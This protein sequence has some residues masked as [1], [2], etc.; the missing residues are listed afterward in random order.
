MAK[1]RNTWGSRSTFILAAVGSAVGLGN[2]W[3]FPGLAAKYGGGTFLMVYLLMMLVMG[4]PLLGMEIAIGRKVKRGAAGSMAGLNKKFEPIGWA[5]TNN[6]FFICTYYAVVFAWVIVMAVIAI[7]KFP[8]MTGNPDAAAGIFDKTIMISKSMT[9]FR[10]PIMVII[11]LI[12]AW[13]AIYYCIRNGVK[14]VSKV[15]KYTV[16]LPVIF[17]VIMA[18]KGI[19]MPHA[20]GGLK[21]FFIPQLGAI[22]NPSLWVDATGQVFYSLSIMMAIMLAYGSFLKDDTNIAMDTIII[23]FSDMAVSV[24]SGIVLFT[25]MYGTGMQDKMTDS[26]IATAF[27]VYPMS[28][29]TMTDS[30]IFNALFGLIFYLCL[31]TLAIDSAFSI[32]EGVSTSFFD[33]FKLRKGKTT[34]VVCII[35]AIISIVYV[36]RSGLYYLDTV[37]HFTNMINL[38]LIG[39]LECVAVG[40]F[41]KTSKV[42]TEINRNTNKFRMP[43]WWFITSVKVISPILLT[44]L[45]VWNIIDLFVTNKGLYS[46]YPLWINIVFGWAFCAIV[47]FSGFVIMFIGK[48]REKAGKEIDHPSWDNNEVN[49]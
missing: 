26:G 14:S 22:N 32:A 31:I 6:A 33:K 16:F 34:L 24:L 37:D 40:W 35:M 9:D 49:E 42:L 4:I 5:A 1:K 39:I 47:F 21:A 45:F 27:Y 29:V 43:S 23:A 19:T 20:I 25:T 15:I 11:C 12:V 2:A 3:R 10:M 41:F 30:G 17:L 7:W 44:G 13:G 8:A 36:T 28:I 18:A 48:R 38:I 46:G